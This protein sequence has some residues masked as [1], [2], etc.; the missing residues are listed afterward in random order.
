MSDQKY[1]LTPEAKGKT[2]DL[3][4]ING[5]RAA[6]SSEK[7]TITLEAKDA[8]ARPGYTNMSTFKENLATAPFIKELLGK[9]NEIQLKNLS[10]PQLDPELG[11]PSITF[12]VECS[13]AEKTR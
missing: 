5:Y 12:R 6:S 1:L 9:T 4:Q 10:Q 7:I 13:F 8:S 2:N 3:G 11:R